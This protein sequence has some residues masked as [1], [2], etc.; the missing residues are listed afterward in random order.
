[1]GEDPGATPSSSCPAESASS[2]V[3]VAASTAAPRIT[4]NAA[5]V[6]SRSSPDA[7]M[8]LASPISPSSHGRG[9]VR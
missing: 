9:N 1:M 7:S 8:T 5:V 3:A 2:A 6:T 4:G